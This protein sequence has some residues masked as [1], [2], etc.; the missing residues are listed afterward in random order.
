MIK[1][2]NKDLKQ[3][4][5]PMFEDWETIAKKFDNWDIPEPMKP[6]QWEITPE[7]WQEL[8]SL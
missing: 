7:E 1:N 4:T 6:E 2:N 5:P 8:T 3:N